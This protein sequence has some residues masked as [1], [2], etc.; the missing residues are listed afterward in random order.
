MFPGRQGMV[1][2]SQTKGTCAHGPLSGRV[3]LLSPNGRHAVAGA[4]H[5]RLMSPSI[6]LTLDLPPPAGSAPSRIEIGR[7]QGTVVVTVHGEFD[8]AT[9][10]QLRSMLADLID[11]QGNLSLTVDLHDATVSPTDADDLSVFADAA[12]RAHRRGGAMTLMGPP[13]LLHAA[14]RRLCSPGG[15]HR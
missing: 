4:P 14:H 15:S 13:P 2:V 3:R 10:A 9:A 1:R 12:R 8:L 6:E 5:L 7:H 11:G